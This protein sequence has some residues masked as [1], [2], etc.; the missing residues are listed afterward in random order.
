MKVP[1]QVL[2]VSS[3]QTYLIIS[4]QI[5]KHRTIIIFDCEQAIGVDPRTNDVHKRVIAISQDFQ[6]GYTFG[7]SFCGVLVELT[8]MLRFSKVYRCLLIC[9]G[10]VYMPAWRDHDS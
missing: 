4:V 10:P 9:C 1:R 3:L 2:S 5:G 7:V 8:R 6:R